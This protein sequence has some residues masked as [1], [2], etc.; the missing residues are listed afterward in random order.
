MQKTLSER[1]KGEGILSLS[2]ATFGIRGYGEFAER[3]DMMVESGI[4]QLL[5]IT[6]HAEVLRLAEIAP[7]EQ[8][9]VNLGLEH[10]RYAAMFEDNVSFVKERYPDLPVI[11]TPMI[12]DVISFGMPNFVRMCKRSGV[13]GMDTA[14]YP[15]I[16]DPVNFRRSLEKEGIAFICAVNGGSV[17]MEDETAVAVMDDL[18]RTT[19][20]ELFYVPGIP[21]TQSDIKGAAVKPYIDR[22]R[23]VQDGCGNRCPII[24]IGGIST[25]EQAYEMV[26]IAGTDGVHF[27]SAFMKRI[28]AGE[29]LEKIGQWLCQVKQAMKED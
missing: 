29:P 21:G 11:V 9:M 25:A 7:A 14:Q 8:H 2:L 19:S 23:A 27:S 22:I 10:G 20:G 1:P 5:L 26:N 16:E 18:V 13:D 4:N 3:L 15:A 17:R 12:G 28:F 24:S 6:Y